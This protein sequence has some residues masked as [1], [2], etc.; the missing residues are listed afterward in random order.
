MLNLL[1]KNYL[2]E[3]FSNAMLSIFVRICLKEINFPCQ[4]T[5]L[6]NASRI[7]L[8]LTMNYKMVGPVGLEPTTTPL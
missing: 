7:L 5:I 2:E 8:I 6:E 4:K 1:R 3:Q